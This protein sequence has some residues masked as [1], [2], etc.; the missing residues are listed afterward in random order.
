[1]QPVNERAA[2]A[3]AAGT[4][5]GL[6]EADAKSSGAANSAIEQR[7]AA[8]IERGFAK[9][10][11]ERKR[12]DDAVAQLKYILPVF[13]VYDPTISDAAVKTLPLLDILE[14]SQ[15][16]FIVMPARERRLAVASF[17]E[18]GKTLIDVKGLCS[19]YINF[20]KG[21]K[22]PN[23]YLQAMCVSVKQGFEVLAQQASQPLED[24]DVSKRPQ[25]RAMTLK[26][27]QEM[28]E[29]LEEFWQHAQGKL[30][31][32]N[33]YFQGCSL[34]LPKQKK[35]AKKLKSKGIKVNFKSTANLF[36]LLLSALPQLRFYTFQWLPNI[37]RKC[38]E[39][40]LASADASFTI[41][42][43]E[44]LARKSRQNIQKI[45]QK[46]TS[47][48]AFFEANFCFT[49]GLLPQTVI[50]NRL[51]REI[52][53]TRV[54]LEYEI[55]KSFVR[56][57]LQFDALQPSDLP[58]NITRQQFDDFLKQI[59]KGIIAI[60]DGKEV[61]PKSLSPGLTTVFNFW[62]TDFRMQYQG[63]YDHFLRCTESEHISKLMVKNVLE[64]WAQIFSNFNLDMMQVSKTET[65]PLAP[66]LSRF[67]FIF[68]ESIKNIPKRE[69]T[70]ESFHKWQ[71]QN[72]GIEDIRRIGGPSKSED[73]DALEEIA[74]TIEFASAILVSANIL[75]KLF[76]VLRQIQDNI[77]QA[78]DHSRALVADDCLNLLVWEEN[79][80]AERITA[81][82]DEKQRAS[83][84]AVTDTHAAAAGAAAAPLPAPEAV[85]AKPALPVCFSV[86]AIQSLFEMRC[87]LAESLGM[88]PAVVALPRHCAGKVLSLSKLAE[89]QHI[90]AFGEFL[91]TAELL[92]KSSAQDQMLISQFFLQWGHLALEQGLTIEHALKFP[93]RLLR[94]EL[95]FLLQHLGIDP[96]GNIWS[97]R[98]SGQSLY[99]RY[100]FYYKGVLPLA[101]Q[102]IRTRSAETLAEFNKSMPQWLAGAAEMHIAALQH[103]SAQHPQLA[104]IQSASRALQATLSK[105]LQSEADQKAAPF[106]ITP[107]QAKKLDSAEKRLADSL[108]TLQKI[109]ADEKGSAALLN[110]RHHLS[111][112]LGTLRLLKQFP[113]QRFLHT[114]AHMALSSIK[115]FAEN[116]G[117]Y[118]SFQSE[119]GPVYTHVLTDLPLEAALGD[120]DDLKRLLKMINIGKGDDYPHAYFAHNGDNALSHWMIKLNE[121]FAWSQEAVLLGEGAKPTGMQTKTPS[122]L[123]EEVVIMSLHFV[124]LAIALLQKRSKG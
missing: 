122:A 66:E 112:L 89:Y 90:H 47:Q 41:N 36:H 80:H 109:S 15:A 58:E 75:Q 45:I 51:Q 76:G 27:A 5:P 119:D 38:L 102:H 111:N 68:N 49:N 39:I 23:T 53:R 61:K 6:P 73:K 40:D 69:L 25:M 65:F 26:V 60:S 17:R 118:L 62:S 96:K 13:K 95:D 72:F 12:Y 78:A 81:E 108:E 42:T 114:L 8:A 120:N 116:Y 92:F 88:N 20:W 24:G 30:E 83:T 52:H 21:C 1:M 43:L 85:P 94:H 37:K 44:A 71:H 48:L 91:L 7:L 64:R 97:T 22:F 31:E 74:S 84:A 59:G 124:E 19:T 4:S 46:I 103:R 79:V 107:E 67:A 56:A 2:S 33:R 87:A 86:P 35:E 10:E 29:F 70:D 98:A 54:I 55:P 101:L 110:A 113:Q 11:T 34:L 82:K 77:S 9:L 63:L 14:V 50:G 32:H 18:F 105:P 121:W 106:E 93:K 57:A 99:Q 123:H 3:T 28:C 104:T 115:N 16:L 117:T 100:P